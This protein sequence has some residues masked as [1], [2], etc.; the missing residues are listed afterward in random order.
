MPRAIYGMAP[1]SGDHGC[2]TRSP[3][4]CDKRQ[5]V[6]HADCAPPPRQEIVCGWPVSQHDS[7][8][9]RALWHVARCT[10]RG[11]EQ[12]VLHCPAESPRPCCLLAASVLESVTSTLL[13]RPQLTPPF[14]SRD[15]RGAENAFQAVRRHQRRRGA[16][17]PSHGPLPRLRLRAAG[18][19]Q[20]LR[21]RPSR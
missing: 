2:V 13:V 17:R 20:L 15:R 16:G 10:L 5:G 4:T 18:R 6:V 14:L 1:A 12:C 9:A 7:R 8:C 19:L 21:C 11:R 3:C